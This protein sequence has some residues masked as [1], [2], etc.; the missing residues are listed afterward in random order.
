MSVFSF[1]WDTAYEASP[2]SGLSR[3]SI[4]DILRQLNRGL[5]ER[6]EVEHNVGYTTESDDGTHIP[7]KTTVALMDD[8]A[9]LAALSDMQDGAVYVQDDGAN[10]KVYVYIDGT[11]WVDFTNDDHG[12]LENLA[13]DSAHDQYWVADDDLDASDSTLNMGGN[14]LEV[15]GTVTGGL[16]VS[17]HVV[18]G[19]T[20][21]SATALKDGTL[22]RQHLS[23][24]VSTVTDFHVAHGEFIYFEVPS[25]AKA[26]LAISIKSSAGNGPIYLGCFTNSGSAVPNVAALNNSG[27]TT[28]VTLQVVWI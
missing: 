3:G 7:G 9:A 17:E 26:I 2:S 10:I 27:A 15:S 12:Q 20:L 28:A 11:G 6:F 4:D 24:N 1:T 16:K 8:A 14:Y 18:N 22:G 19:H 13:L 21:I 25:T 23:V 5:R